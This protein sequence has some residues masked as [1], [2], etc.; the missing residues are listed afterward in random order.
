M[1]L[2][3]NKK[4]IAIIDEFKSLQQK[5]LAVLRNICETN[6]GKVE[7]KSDIAMDFSIGFAGCE[8]CNID[9]LLLSNGK[10]YVELSTCDFGT[11]HTVE[12]IKG[13]A[14]EILQII[15][16]DTHLQ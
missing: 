1:N 6:G 13:D 5:A 12:V 14:I 10:L 8:M 15:L 4:A 11:G 7:V 2:E 3:N 9:S 16:F